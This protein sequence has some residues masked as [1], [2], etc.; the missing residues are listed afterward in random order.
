VVVLCWRTDD[1]GTDGSGTTQ[2]VLRLGADP[3]DYVRQ[4]AEVGPERAGGCP[5]CPDGHRL[6]AHGC[7]WRWILVP[8]GER[9]AEER[10][11]V[12]RFLCSRTG[13]TVS[14]L[15]D[16]CLPR[17][18]HGVELV[19]AL[20]A[21][22]VTLGASLASAFT[23]LGR[24]VEGPRTAQALVAGFVARRPRLEAYAARLRRRAPDV[25][26]GLSSYRREVARLFLPLL[27]GRP[28]GADA[29]RHHGRR[30]HAQFGCGIA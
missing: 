21:A 14:L 9:A 1:R 30:F 24:P 10:L 8:D 23:R 22:V 17:R 13:R 18:R 4:L 19:G 20:L 11:P 25:P 15:P 29:L 12:K 27:E 3:N 6:R 26:T 16:F 5:Y 2:K 7:Y 28:S